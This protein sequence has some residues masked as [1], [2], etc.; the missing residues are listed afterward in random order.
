M[1]KFLQIFPQDF[2]AVAHDA[3]NVITEA[4]NEKPCLS[5]NGN[6]R[7]LHDTDMFDCMRKVISLV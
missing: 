2:V 4:L 5:L 7:L 3:I 6:D 1:T